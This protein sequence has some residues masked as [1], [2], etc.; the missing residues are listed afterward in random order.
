M[1]IERTPGLRA[2]VGRSEEEEHRAMLSAPSLAYRLGVG[3]A[4]GVAAFAIARPRRTERRLYLKGSPSP[5]RA[6]G[7]RDGVPG[8][9]LDEAFGPSAPERFHL[10]CFADN[11]RAQDPM[12]S[13]ASPATACCAKPTGWPTGREPTSS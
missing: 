6:R 13:S 8:P 3:E 12:R 9:V 11:V 4:G 5:A 2:F 10:D 1:A 7:R